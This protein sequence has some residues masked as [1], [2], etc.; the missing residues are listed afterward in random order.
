ML[1]SDAVISHSL[2]KMTQKERKRF[3]DLNETNINQL[4][5]YKDSASTKRIVLNSATLFNLFLKSK[6][7]DPSIVY[8]KV[9]LNDVLRSFYHSIRRIKG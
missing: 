4:L 6:N 2:I 1:Q 5:E 9:R 3:V 7:L 8:D